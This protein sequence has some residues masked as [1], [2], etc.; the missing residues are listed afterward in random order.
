MY[1]SA[2]EEHRRCCQGEATALPAGAA[3]AGPSP[4]PA[5]ASVPSAILLFLAGVRDNAE[6]LGGRRRYHVTFARDWRPTT[7]AAAAP[8]TSNSGAGCENSNGG[9]DGHGEHD[10]GVLRDAREIL[11]RSP[12]EGNVSSYAKGSHV[13]C[14]LHT[15]IPNGM[16]RGSRWGEARLGWHPLHALRGGRT[17][18]SQRVGG[19]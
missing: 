13:F 9:G 4:K 2:S 16:Q 6:A 3:D 14:V 11:Q 15:A 17:S 8:R 18:G 12:V 10:D 7:A 19:P 5:A 1:S